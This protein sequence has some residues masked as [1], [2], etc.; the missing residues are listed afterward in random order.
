MTDAD[1]PL[2]A[3]GFDPIFFGASRLTVRELDRFRRTRPIVMLHAS[4]HLMN[5]NSPMLALAGIDDDTE[6][7]GIDTDDDGQPTGELQEFAAMFP[8]YRVIG[9]DLSIA[10]SE[11]REAIWNFGQVAQLAGVTTATDLVNDLSGLGN[12]NLREVT[13]RPD[14]PVRI[15]PAFA[16]QTKPG[17]RRRNACSPRHARQHRQAALRPGQVHRRRLDPG[18][19]GAA[20]WPG[21]F[22]GAAERHVA[23]SAGQFD[24]V[25]TPFHAAGLQL[26]IHTNGDEAT[27]VVLDAIETSSSAIRAAI[28]ATRCSTARWPTRASSRARRGS[29]CAST[30]SPTIS[31][32]GATRTTRRPWAP[33]ARI[34]WTPAAP[35]SRL[36]IPFAF[37]SDAPITPLS[38]LFTAWCAVAAQTLDGPR[39]RRERV[40]PR[41]RR[42]ARDHAGRGLH[43]Q[44]GPSDRQYRGRQVRRLLRAA[45]RP[46]EVAP[47]R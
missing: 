19:H 31:T 28:T 40:H 35:R 36:G 26:H 17:Q 33:T 4:V 44:D 16:P 22:N 37:H 3:W 41:G 32:T 11:N 12:R 21:Y 6:I 39:A 2:L 18:L 9:N 8:V 34:G 43:A 45:R 42:V 29:A 10:A 23:D 5:V 47:E 25:F 14:Y 27:E 1:A 38:P 46:A 13:A 20:E 7:D 30:C 24:E 15:V